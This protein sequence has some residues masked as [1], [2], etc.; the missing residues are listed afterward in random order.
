MAADPGHPSDFSVDCT[1]PPATMPRPM[2]PTPAA[3]THRTAH[4]LT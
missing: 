2:H 3:A 1:P 4:F